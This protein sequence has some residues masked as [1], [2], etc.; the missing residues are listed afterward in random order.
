MFTVSNPSPSDSS[1]SADSS[2]NDLSDSVAHDNQ[3][4]LYSL[5]N[6]AMNGQA[7]NVVSSSIG[8]LSALEVNT[9]GKWRKGFTLAEAKQYSRIKG[10]MC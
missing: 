9:K 8:G 10:I 2:H 7:R 3:Y 5:H 4:K 6:I 1:P